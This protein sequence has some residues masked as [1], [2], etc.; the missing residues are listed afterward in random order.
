MS[1]SGQ[2]PIET[3]RDQQE[4]LTELEYFDSQRPLTPAEQQRLN[5][6]RQNAGSIVASAVQQVGHANPGSPVVSGDDSP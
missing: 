1:N 3:P 4:E 2:E 5:E 6:L